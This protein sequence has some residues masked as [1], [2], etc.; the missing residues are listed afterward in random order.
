MDAERRTVCWNG[1]VKN[2][3]QIIE[4]CMAS[5]VS[6]LDYWVVV[7]TGSSDGTQEIIRNFMDRHG[8]PGELMERPWV[9]FAHNRSEAIELA[10]GK[11]DYLL[12]CDADMALEVQDPNWKSTLQD[13]AYMVTQMAHQG[14]LS[15]PNVR[16]INARLKDDQRFRYWGATH[17]YCDSIEPGL[18]GCQ[19]L[20][21]VTMRDYGD[22]GSKSDKFERDIRLLSTQVAELQAL[23]GQDADTRNAAHKSGLLRHAPHL[24]RRNTFYLARSYSDCGQLEQAIAAYERRIEQGGWPEEIWYSLFQIAELKSRLGRPDDEVIQAFLK[25]YE[26]R[27]A[28]AEA[29]HH[30]ARHLRQK[31]RFALAY[32]YAAAACRIPMPKDILFM[33]PHVYEW[34]AKDECAVA[35]YWLDRFEE[36]AGLCRELLTDPRVGE[37]ERSRIQANLAFALERL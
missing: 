29:L 16:L 15:Y 20:S 24:I 17:E 28:R 5:M 6:E 25:A 11:A 22:G 33:S 14:S 26:Y 12:F 9:N 10:E 32:A 3:S 31:S 19:V 18:A 8:V 7:D 27:P 37:N 4:R 13:Q 21:G 34:Q 35:A 30:L 23:D 2:E 36:S 1:I